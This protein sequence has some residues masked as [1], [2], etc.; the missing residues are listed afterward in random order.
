MSSA[1]D[2]PAAVPAPAS[3]DSNG[4]WRLLVAVDLQAV[5]ER[6]AQS[7]LSAARASITADVEVV[8]E[9]Q[10]G[11]PREVLIAASERFGPSVL[12]VGARRLGG[13]GSL[14][15]GST[16]RWVLHHASCPVLVARGWP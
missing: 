2:A 13:F 11:P 12:V 7:A 14:L 4:S 15:L 6:E 3:C 10:Q 5:L 16:S 8:E 1:H 9:L